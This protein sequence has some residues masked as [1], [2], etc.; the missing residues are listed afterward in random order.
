MKIDDKLSGSCEVLINSSASRTH[1]VIRCMPLTQYPRPF[2]TVVLAMSADGKIT[3]HE[4]SPARFG[5]IAD[6]Y[7]LETQVAACDAVL[8][9]AETL[10]AYGTTLRVTSSDLLAQRQQAGQPPQPVHIVCSASGNLA[11]HLR[12][13]QQSVSRWLLTTATGA[14]PWQDDTFFE[15]VLVYPAGTTGFVWVTVLQDLVDAGIQR[16][17]ILGG[18]E[19][20]ASLLAEGLVDHL[21]LTVCPLLLGGRNAP[22]PV[23]GI[24]FAAAIAPRLKLLNVRTL[25]DEVFLTYQVCH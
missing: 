10:R 17:A 22:T 21:C 24:G 11:T 25:E 4:R 6:K 20:V 3:D 23:E 2:T 12:F 14:I 9:G 18:G 1:P 8:F 13:F 19:L 16:L 15:R 7:H 5:S